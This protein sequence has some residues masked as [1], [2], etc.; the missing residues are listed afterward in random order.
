[1]WY[2][3]NDEMRVLH[4]IRPITIYKVDLKTG[5]ATPIPYQW[6]RGAPDGELRGGTPLIK[7]N[8]SFQFG[9]AHRTYYRNGLLCHSPFVVAKINDKFEIHPVVTPDHVPLLM[10]PS[11]ILFMN[12][13]YYVIIT[14]A[15][16]AWAG[17]QSY[18]VNVYRIMN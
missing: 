6:D 18:A 11:C 16:S 1:M 5:F 3:E 7:V 14:E 10:D 8:R 17:P 4:Q 9:L 15:D 2:E 12:D 13:T